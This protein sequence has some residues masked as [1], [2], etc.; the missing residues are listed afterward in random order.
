MRKKVLQLG[1]GEW[2]ARKVE[3]AVF[4]DAIV[5]K[6]DL[7]DKFTE[8]LQP[9]TGN[10]DDAN[11]NTPLPQV[12]DKDEDDY[13]VTPP[14]S[15]RTHRQKKSEVESEDPASPPSKKRKNSDTE[16]DTTRRKS[17]RLAATE[18]E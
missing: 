11:E 15:S 10:D 13:T 12:D 4:V 3:Q 7:Q 1:A 8:F 2:D 14:P 17:S 16:G 6:H 9:R 5:E 18:S